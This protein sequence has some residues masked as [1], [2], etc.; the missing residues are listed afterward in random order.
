VLT[1]SA[2]L[3]TSGTTDTATFFLVNTV[4]LLPLDDVTGIDKVYT[5]YSIP[6]TGYTLDTLV[7]IR[8]TPVF[9]AYGA[10][11]TLE[12]IPVLL[13]FRTAGDGT[14]TYAPVVKKPDLVLGGDAQV[15]DIAFDGVTWA[16]SAKTTTVDT[17]TFAFREFRLVDFAVR[18]AGATTEAAFLAAR[19]PRPWSA[20]PDDVKTLLGHFSSTTAFALTLV[21]TVDNVTFPT[22]YTAG[23]PDAENALS[24][25]GV[26]TD[27][28]TA[29][30]FSDGS[31][32]WY[33]KAPST[34]GAPRMGAARLPELPPGFQYGAVAIV[35]TTVY[36]AW[37]ERAFYEVGRTGFAN[38]EGR[39]F[40]R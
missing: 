7:T 1:S 4:G 20:A 24:A 22:T 2:W 27:D 39:F 8:G 33:T 5:V 16:A 29:V 28:V 40:W 19:S 18:D 37:E 30:L 14:G 13:G 34:T 36:A 15:S 38:A 9:H 6:Y 3:H 23:P 25:S 11:P 35:G 12:Q 21:A 10:A 17:T 32:F 26:H 31:F